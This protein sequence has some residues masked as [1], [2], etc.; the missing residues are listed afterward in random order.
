VTV[1]ESNGCIVVALD[2]QH[3]SCPRSDLRAK[4]EWRGTP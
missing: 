3:W 4:Q 1:D 2:R